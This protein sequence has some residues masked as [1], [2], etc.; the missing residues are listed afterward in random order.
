MCARSGAPPGEGQHDQR[1]LVR[2]ST[3][4]GGHYTRKA[5][6]LDAGHSDG[7]TRTQ[8]VAYFDEIP[9]RRTASAP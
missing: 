2:L 3:P 5:Y 1:V 8:L 4:D 9:V 6:R 7:V